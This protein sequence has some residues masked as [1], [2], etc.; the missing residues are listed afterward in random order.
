MVK[1]I[2]LSFRNIRQWFNEVMNVQLTFWYLLLMLHSWTSKVGEIYER[3]PGMWSGGV[4]GPKSIL[5]VKSRSKALETLQALSE[6]QEMLTTDRAE[7]EAILRERQKE[8]T[9]SA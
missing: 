7:L 8:K 4:V 6:E 2:K 1:R 5:G 3:S 9:H